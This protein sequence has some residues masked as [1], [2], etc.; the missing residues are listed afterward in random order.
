MPWPPLHYAS[1]CS[2]QRKTWRY[3]GPQE[4]SVYGKRRSNRSPGQS[5]P[6]VGEYA[7]SGAPG[8]WPRV[9][10]PHCRANTE[11]LYP[12]PAWRHGDGRHLS[13][14][15]DERADHL[16]GS[17]A[18]IAPGEQRRQGLIDGVSSK[19]FLP[20]PGNMLEL[21][22]SIRFRPD[23]EKS[24]LAADNREPGLGNGYPISPPLGTFAE[25]EGNVQEHKVPS[26]A[27]RR[28]AEK[29]AIP[30]VACGLCGGLLHRRQ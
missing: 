2:W 26:G 6:S 8:K 9:N 4:G 22:D 11:K 27:P 12:H 14:R 23:P 29:C 10:R 19:A 16:P 17:P 18:A 7:V 3:P 30:V 24:P 1:V 28:V 13:L 5:R 20:L 25:T 15:F 21:L